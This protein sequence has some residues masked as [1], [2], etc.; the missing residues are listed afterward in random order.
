MPTEE[1]NI[2]PGEGSTANEPVSA[3]TEPEAENP[4]GSLLTNPNMSP[5]SPK[6]DSRAQSNTDGGEGGEPAKAESGSGLL[7]AS[8]EEEE[9]GDIG[10]LGA[11]EEG[12][13]FEDSPESD[14]HI[15]PDTREAFAA[16]AKELNLSQEAAQKVITKME[17]ALCRRVEKLRAQWAEQSQADAEFGGNQFNTNVKAIRRTYMATTT[18][19]LR[20]VFRASGLDSNPEVL[21]H[22]YRLSKELGEGRFVNESG[23][24]GGGDRSERPSFY[25]GMNP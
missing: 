8:D 9:S 24:R 23:T 12:Y 14:V 10:T 21:R 11:P 2:S 4:A 5:E 13:K 18:P 3:K 19:E 25:Q 20:E 1:M 22:F 16:V 7:S 6:E 15:D 17:P